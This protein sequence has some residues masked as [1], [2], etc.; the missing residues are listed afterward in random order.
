MKGENGRR[1]LEALLEGNARFAAGR[2][3]HPRGDTA[4]RVETSRG[5]RPVAVVVS[6]S[7]SRVP[8]E[9]VFDQ[10]IGDLFVVRTP[11]SLVDDVGLGSIEYAVEHLGVALV[12]VLGHS[13]CGA[14]VAAVEG[15]P[16]PGHLDRLVAALRPAVERSRGAE[17]AVDA[18]GRENVKLTI[19]ELRS[20]EPILKPRVAAGEIFV[21]GAFYDL[22]RGMVEIIDG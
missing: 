8:P 21:V 7:D 13:R 4:R 10:G 6:C 1:A 20:A 9:I 17:N 18:A 14:F 11:G 22:A 3:E 19:A 16:L 12:V 2:P 5:Q 15:K